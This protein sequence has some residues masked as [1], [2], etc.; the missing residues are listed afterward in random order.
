[1]DVDAGPSTVSASSLPVHIVVPSS[2][3][4]SDSKPRLLSAVGKHRRDRHRLQRG[5]VARLIS[6]T[7][8]LSSSLMKTLLRVGIGVRNAF[9]IEL[10]DDRNIH[11]VGDRFDAARGVKVT[12]NRTM[13]PWFCWTAMKRW[14]S[15]T[16]PT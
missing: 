3:R 5:A 7:P 4:V 16:G 2:V 1:M 8:G 6:R 14:A 9:E 13:L 15:P 10:G 12:S 11:D